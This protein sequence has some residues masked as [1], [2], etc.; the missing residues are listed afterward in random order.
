MIRINKGRCTTNTTWSD[1]TSRCLCFYIISDAVVV[2]VYV[3]RVVDSVLISIK[4]AVVR[5]RTSCQANIFNTVVTIAKR[6]VYV[7]VS[8]ISSYRTGIEHDIVLQIAYRRSRLSNTQRI[9]GYIITKHAFINTILKY[10]QLVVA[11]KYRIID[12]SKTCC[13][14]VT[15]GVETKKR[16][17]GCSV[18]N[19]KV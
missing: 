5:K 10:N 15:N 12:I 17:L 18:G 4:R 3:M 1:I 2:T 7:V 9:T 6:C 8:R 14:I 13:G 11:N 19:A 16:T